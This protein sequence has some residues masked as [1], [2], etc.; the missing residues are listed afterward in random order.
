MKKLY[1]IFFVAIVLQIND[2][3]QTSFPL[4]IGNK[5]Y[6]QTGSNRNEVY[7]IVKEVTDTL[8]NG[9]R[10]I[11]SKYFSRT[12]VSTGKEYWGFIDGKFYA[13]SNS[14]TIDYYAQVYYD[15]YL[16]HDSCKAN[17]V[18]DMGHDCWEWIEYQLFNIAD[19]AQLYTRTWQLASI[20][21][22]KVIAI[23]S[24]KLG[25][26]RIWSSSYVRQGEGLLDSTYLIGMQRNGEVLG[27]TLTINQ[28]RIP[29]L[30]S[31]LNGALSMPLTLTLQWNKAIEVNSYKLQV[32]TDYDFSNTVADY[33][34]LTDTL[35]VIGPIKDITKFYWRVFAQSNNGY[36][37]VSPIFNF[38]TIINIDNIPK[39]LKPSN[40]TTGVAQP[41]TFKWSKVPDTGTYE[42]QIATDSLCHQTVLDRIV[43]DDT[44]I[45]IDS[46]VTNKKYYW[47]VKK[48]SSDLYWSKAFSFTTEA[49]PIEF[50][51]EQNY[52][53]PFNGTT[54]FI[55]SLSNKSKI[56]VQ[57]FNVLGETVATLLDSEIEPG[58][59][60]LTVDSARLSSG[61]YF[62]QMKAGDFVQTKKMILLR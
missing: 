23:A 47:R 31:P 8:S 56:N 60:F 2:F 58:T 29:S 48:I 34:G 26:A 54:K 12:G 49:A 40:G 62:Y 59:Y 61:I 9:F 46:L 15:K 24:P 1:L 16:T 55:Y 19:S 35:K 37:Y 20:A 5:W 52:P 42:F 32:A 7:G 21:S 3:A 18:G 11:T 30:S 41:L 14:P 38:S 33:S 10:E 6:Y 27:D 13:N 39:L 45:V 53:N 50:K 44:V 25:I 36:E 43:R 57:L 17:Q 22:V 4:D 28:Y 51:L